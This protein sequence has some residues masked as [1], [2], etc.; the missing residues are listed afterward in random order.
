MKHLMI[1]LATTALATSAVTTGAF[2]AES[3]EAAG[4][5]D[6]LKKKVKKAKKAADDANEVVNTVDRANRTNGRS[7]LGAGASRSGVGASAD[8]SYCNANRGSNSNSPCT[9]RAPG[10]AGNAGPAPAK[11]TGQLK[12]ESLGIGNA[13]VGRDGNYTFSQGISTE[14]RS[15]IVDR[16]N[17]SAQNGCFFPGLAVGDILYVEF[18]KNKYN[19]HDYNVQC[20][21]YD[22]SE[23][24]DNTN[25]PRVGNYKGK[26]VM[27]H[28][29]NSLGYTPVAS[30]SNS[31]RSGAYDKHLA[32]RGRAMQTFNFGALH[33]DKSGTDFYCQ[34]FNKKTGQS[35]LALTFRRGPQG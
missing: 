22:G 28:T 27:L 9:A 2:G 20:V 12:C 5:F 19:K 23:Q 35:A 11:F 16:Q 3:V 34:Y 18:D 31:S 29:G 26:D 10:H 8:G 14:E 30:G 1:A 17:V 32:G 21:S 4:P 33:T 13:F 6:K 24:L 7:L 15:G 25:G